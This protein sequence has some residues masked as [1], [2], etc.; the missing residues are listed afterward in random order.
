MEKR[1]RENEEGKGGERTF[2]ILRRDLDC[3]DIVAG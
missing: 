1:G 3:Y 2:V